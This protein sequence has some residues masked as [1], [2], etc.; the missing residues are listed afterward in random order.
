MIPKRDPCTHK[1]RESEKKRKK[2]K[3]YYKYIRDRKM[4]RRVPKHERDAGR[5]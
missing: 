3:E 4:S 1:E 2:N 5:V